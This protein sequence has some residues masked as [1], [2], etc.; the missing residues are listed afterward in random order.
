[1]HPP[2]NGQRPPTLSRAQEE[3]FGA[4]PA[5]LLNHVLWS[6]LLS[7]R[8]EPRKSVRPSL[9]I[10]IGRSAEHEHQGPIGYIDRGSGHQGSVEIVRQC[11]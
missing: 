9:R 4:P 11:G 8:R 10:L 1:M 6:E 7:E 5:V 3:D 2:H